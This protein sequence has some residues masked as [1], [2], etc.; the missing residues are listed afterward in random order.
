SDLRLGA[1][2]SL[3]G[4]ASDPFQLGI[5]AL[6]WVPTGSKAA[7]A[8]D[9][10][11]RGQPLLVAGG[12]SR[13]VVWSLSLGPELRGRVSYTPAS[14]LVAG[15][16]MRWGAGVGFIPGGGSFQIGPELTGGI[17]LG[18]VQKRTTDAELM[19]GSKFRF[20]TS[21]EAGFGAG[22]GLG[23][24]VGTPDFRTV[25]SLA[26]TPPMAP[27]PPAPAEVDRD[28]DRDGDRTPDVRAACPD[29]S[30]VRAPDPAKNGCPP[31]PDRDGDGVPDSQDACP[32]VPGVRDPA[33][34]LDGCPP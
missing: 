34:K 6:V 12:A 30:G 10:A 25:L 3:V 9:G 18:D 16:S 20:A 21:F 13:Y 1:R 29:P 4:A 28:G 22:L 23:G 27:P 31:I 19:V 26:Y 32:D 5:A 8:S 15:P 2:A 24:G 33:P 14:Q 17:S 11:V 7:F